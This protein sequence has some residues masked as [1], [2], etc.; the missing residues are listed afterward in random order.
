VTFGGL[1]VLALRR[2]Y[3]WEVSLPFGLSLIYVDVS[4][5]V[6]VRWL[7]K[8]WRFMHCNGNGTELSGIAIMGEVAQ[9]LNKLSDFL[10]QE[11]W[12]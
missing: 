2:R 11:M 7:G 10:V 3:L 12:I 1:P 9:G 4:D 5:L 6:L 8:C